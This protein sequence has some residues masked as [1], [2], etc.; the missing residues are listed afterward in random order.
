MSEQK[1]RKEKDTFGDLQVPA[2]RYWG[3]QTQRS[4]LNFDIGVYDPPVLADCR[5]TD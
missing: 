5:R 4:L 2:E 3:A 1:Y